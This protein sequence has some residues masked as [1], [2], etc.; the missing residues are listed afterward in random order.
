MRSLTLLS[1]IGLAFV[2]VM[3]VFVAPEA[4]PTPRLPLSGNAAS[5]CDQGPSTSPTSIIYHLDHMAVDWGVFCEGTPTWALNNVTTPSLDGEALQCAITGG[6]PYSN[7]HCY[8]TLLP[9]YTA[10]AFTMTAPFQFNQ[11]TTCNNAGGIPSMVQ[12][13]EFTM[14]KWQQGQRYEWALQWQ[15][16]GPGAPQ[17][18][19]W[20]SSQTP[21]QRWAPISPT[22]STCLSAGQ[23]YTLTLEGDLVAGQV[24]YQRFSLDGQAHPLNIT[25]PPAA[26]P[27]EPDRLAVGVQLDGNS[28]Q[29]PY[30]FVIDQ[31][32]FIRTAKCAAVYTGGNGWVVYFTRAQ[33]ALL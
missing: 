16:V 24:H 19:Y 9:D 22:L 12:A 28:A 10:T 20:D 32:S 27:G 31:V 2:L 17:W 3:G 18:R 25:V 13:L 29:T 1:T 4:D 6:Q 15:N 7:V 5:P 14:N 8:R 30:S 33:T 21:A 11:A 26:V 23:W